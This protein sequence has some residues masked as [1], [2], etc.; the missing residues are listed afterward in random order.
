MIYRCEQCFISDDGVR[1][2]VVGSISL[3]SMPLHAHTLHPDCAPLFKRGACEM[4]CS[5]IVGE[6][7]GRGTGRRRRVKP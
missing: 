2:F 1:Q 6:N 4:C 3:G 5:V 7:G